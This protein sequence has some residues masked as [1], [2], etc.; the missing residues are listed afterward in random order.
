[1]SDNSA[2]PRRGATSASNAAYDSACPGRHQ[3]QRGLVGESSA[4]ADFGI[5]IHY[6]L[7]KNDPSKL[8]TEQLDIYESCIAIEA[9]LVDELFGP[10]RAK[11]KTFIEQRFWV[12]VKGVDGKTYHDH[13]GQPDKIYRFGPRG[14]II[15]WKALAGDVPVSAENQQLRD[16]VVLAAGN[17]VLTEVMA[18]V[19]QPLV[20]HDPAPCLYDKVSIKQ[21]EEEMFDRVRRSNDHKAMRIPGEVACKFCLAKPVCKEYAKWSSALLPARISLPDLP[22]SEWTVDQRVSFCEGVG[23]VKKWIE[24]NE[25]AMKKLLNDDADAV[26]GF[27]LKPGNIREL[28]TDPEALFARFVELGGTLEQFIACVSIAKGKLEDQVRS[29]TEKKGKALKSQ[30]DTLLEGIV[31]QKQNAPSLAKRK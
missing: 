29:V 15:E 9:K 18:V 6:A 24:D 13:S 27:Y 3:A 12:K 16:Q 21:A 2:D 17:L 1:M 26:P 25:E 11:V 7:A 8:T 31:E 4:D 19:I 20:T 23:S 14:L 22:V 30:V 10:D 28:V 5:G